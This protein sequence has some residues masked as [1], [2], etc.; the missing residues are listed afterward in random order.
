MQ[1]K[2]SKGRVFVL[3]GYAYSLV[4]K[5]FHMYGYEVVSKLEDSDIVCFLGG[6]DINPKLYGETEAG[7][8]GWNDERD[9]YEVDI[10]NRCG[11]RFKVGICRGGQLL[12]VLNGGSLWQDVNNHNSGVHS[13]LDYITNEAVV[14]NSLHHQQM[15]LGDA[16]EL[17]AGCH[18][19]SK[20][21]SYNA[22]WSSSISKADKTNK[23]V[24]VEV[25]FYEATKSLCFQPHPQLRPLGSTGKYF[26][27]LLDRFYHAA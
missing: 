1:P 24:D 26:K 8:E 14:V 4:V 23:D 17:V 19:S 22:Y 16:G 11:T 13:V 3:Q 6:D 27:S 10:Y 20:K 21:D 9:A 12:N 25:A 18:L 5:M 15:R 2:K 7:A